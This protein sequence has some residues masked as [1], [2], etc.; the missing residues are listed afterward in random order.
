[1]DL[2]LLSILRDG[3]LRRSEAAALTWGDVKLPDNG[4]R[5]I[6]VRRSKTDQQG[7]GVTLY[8]GSQAGEAL[9]AIKPADQLLDRKHTHLRAFTTPD[10]QES[11]R[12]GQGRR[13]G[14][15]VHR[16][17]RPRGDSPR[18]GQDRR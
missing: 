2:A 5:L 6:N 1:M 18:S 13:P 12:R 16:P 4:T 14:R 17:Q 15:G 11:Q 9:T 10:R 7:E 8:I 3:F